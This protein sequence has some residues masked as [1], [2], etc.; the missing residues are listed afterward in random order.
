MDYDYHEIL[1]QVITTAGMVYNASAHE[2]SGYNQAIGFSVAAATRGGTV[3]L[4]VIGM[5]TLSGLTIGSEYYLSD[6]F[7]NI[8]VSAGTNSKKVG[9][10]YTTTQLLINNI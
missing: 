3:D 8:S 9:K 2:T 5:Q 4:N 10:A 6:T 7:G 1:L